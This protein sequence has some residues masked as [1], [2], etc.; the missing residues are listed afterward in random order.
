MWSDRVHRKLQLVRDGWPFQLVPALVR[1]GAG[2]AGSAALLVE[3]RDSEAVEELVSRAVADLAG[4]DDPTWRLADRIARLRDADP[5]SVD[6][7][8]DWLDA[9]LRHGALGGRRR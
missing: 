7:A 8:V 9:L 6:L 3:D 1:L 4:D 2:G 5:E